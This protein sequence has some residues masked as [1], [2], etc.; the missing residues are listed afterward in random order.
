MSA[1]L[2]G[3]HRAAVLASATLFTMVASAP[4]GGVAAP[5]LT[6]VAESAPATGLP[7]GATVPTDAIRAPASVARRGVVVP[8]TGRTVDRVLTSPSA[9][10]IPQAAL[11]AY[12]R[13]ETVINAVDE[14]C[15]ISWQ[16]IA[17]IGRVESDH[18]RV[19][20]SSLDD[21]GLAEPGI[22]GV[23]LDGDGGTAVI[24][25][26]DSGQYD[27]DAR[28]DRAVGPMQFIPS[29]WSVVGVDG[30]DD[31][32]RNPQDIDDAALAT[33]VYLCSGVDDLSTD[34]GRRAAV[35]R[36]NHSH[37]Y[38]DL[39]LSSMA[40]Y[41]EV[42]LTPVS[43]AAVAVASFS[44]APPVREP[45]VRQREDER[46]PAAGR[47]DDAPTRGEDAPTP[48]TQ[49][50]SPDGAPGPGGEPTDPE[51]GG[52]PTEP[53]TE[54]EPTDP[55][56]G[57]EPTDPDTGAEPTDPDTGGEP[58]DPDA[59]GEP[60]DPDTGGEPVVDPGLEEATA[61]CLTEVGA[62][63]AEPADLESLGLLE[64]FTECMAARG[65]TV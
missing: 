8:R 32:E 42:D 9:L 57:G 64:E 25:D 46:R 10:D 65:F 19:H 53:D 21:A 39:V 41:L 34:R 58:T 43:S 45:S 52:E 56:T 17:A 12:Q 30:D 5:T 48:G 2:T 20:G 14:T 55:D 3:R 47:N 24:R 6:A 36:Y 37:H 23:A 54:G 26:T 35:F 16:L 11:A 18:G 27:G 62:P 28:W 59:G 13:A 22:F 29:T 15:N 49:P 31:G 38:V 1:R 33:A 63:T 61:E 50:Q 51:T 4:W 40:A 7:D 60:T 44:V